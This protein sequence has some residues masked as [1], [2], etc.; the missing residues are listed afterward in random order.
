MSDNEKKE[1][2]IIDTLLEKFSEELLKNSIIGTLQKNFN[3]FIQKPCYLSTIDRYY[4]ATF[5]GSQIEY[6]L[7]VP[8]KFDRFLTSERVDYVTNELKDRL[9]QYSPKSVEFCFHG[10]REIMC[11]KVVI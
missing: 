3:S 6:M 2:D 1:S 4:N 5:D 7:S 11:L 9:S 8:V 10:V